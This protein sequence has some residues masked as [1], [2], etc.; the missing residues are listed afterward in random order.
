[1]NA[2]DAA[3]ANPTAAARNSGLPVVGYLA[4]TSPVEM[5]RAAGAF[6]QQVNGSPSDDTADALAL[7]EDFTDGW[8]LSVFQQ[9]LDGRLDH[10]DALIVPRS[11][12]SMLQLYYQI[13]DFIR[14]N[15]SRKLPQPIL[16]DILHTPYPATAKYNMG[17]MV[18]MRDRMAMLTGMAV[19]DD[20]L[21]AAIVEANAVRN[22]LAKQNTRRIAGE[23]AASTMWQLTRASTL[24]APDDFLAACT[25]VPSMAAPDGPRLL[26]TGSPHD[27]EA[28][29]RLV[30]SLG[31]AITGDDHMAGDWWFL[32]PVSAGDP[33]QALVDKYHLHAPSPRSFPHEVCDA[34]LMAAARRSRARAVIFFTDARDDVLGFDYPTQRD[35]LAEHGLP[36]LFMPGQDY[37]EPERAAQQAQVIEFMS[38]LGVG[39]IVA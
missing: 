38:S 12:E 19:T 3:I 30:E 9:L 11:S 25:D 15:P 31:G 34:R 27:T 8:I 22:C 13:Q 1:L 37:R 17:R 7:M 21:S 29:H 28:F 36:V 26:L 14:L 16:F 10:L 35:L 23:I 33:M 4:N 24:I 39:E 6:A 5:I 32:D 20:A 18:A 2:I